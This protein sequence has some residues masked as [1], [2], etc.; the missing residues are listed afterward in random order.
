MKKKILVAVDGSYCSQNVIHYLSRLFGGHAEMAV[1]L[2]CFVAGGSQPVNSQWLTEDDKM[3]MLSAETKKKIQLTKKHL[4]EEAG[5]L[6]RHGFTENQVSFDL[7]FCRANIATDLIH[8]M[9]KGTYDALVIGR[10][11]LGKL[12]EL[13]L[14]SVTTAILE[15]C[16]NV[17]IWIIDGDI[18]SRR[19]LVPV[20]G[21]WRTLKAID[22]LGFMV[23]NVA[24]VEISLFHSTAWLTPKKPLGIDKFCDIWGRE[25]CD[26]HLSRSDAVFH[27]PE[28]LLRESGFDMSRVYRVEESMGPVAAL[29][30]M[31]EL[32]NKKYGTI[33]MGR[34]GPDEPKGIFGGVSGRVL[35]TVNDVAV[36]LVN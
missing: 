36:W 11:G 17:P 19:F 32:R 27:G 14:G 1:H 15:K 9:H 35:R 10:R 21:S 2:V 25:W 30:I 7:Q 6:T 8:E 12:Q 13:V 34:R 23:G 31:L 24:D 26:E 22:H 16:F 28:Q 3:E 18:D 4:R 5:F 33:V 29:D 20:D